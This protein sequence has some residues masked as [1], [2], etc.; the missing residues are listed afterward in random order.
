MNYQEML[1]HPKWQ[2]KRLEILE[3]HG[4]AC[5]NCHNPDKQLHV[6]HG[7]YDNSLKL[8]EYDNETLHCYC[9]ECHKEAHRLLLDLYKKI[10]S[11]ADFFH[12]D[13]VVTKHFNRT[14]RVADRL[15]HYVSEG[16]SESLD[17]HLAKF[18]SGD[19]N[20]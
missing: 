3:Y 11:E 14:Y 20:G 17:Q 15:S 16:V 10:A 9:S 6:H 13:A 7:Y 19:D 5:E 18:H 1:K 8:W 12:F 4:F 2:K